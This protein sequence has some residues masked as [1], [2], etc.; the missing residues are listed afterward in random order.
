MDKT[1]EGNA[2]GNSNKKSVAV[3]A[4]TVIAIIF[5]CFHIYAA[6]FGT[7]GAFLQ[8]SIHLTFALV[9]VL[10][11]HPYKRW[12]RAGTF[13]NAIMI[14]GTVFVGIYA[15]VSYETM[16]DRAG[17]PNTLDVICGILTILLL[18]EASRRILGWALSIIASVCIAYVLFGYLLPPAVGHPGFTP[19][20]IIY[21]LYMTTEGIF[22][23]PLGVSA[24]FIIL[25]T[26]FGAV[27]IETGGSKFIS[28]LAFALFGR[29][30]GGP[31]KACVVSSAALGTMTGAAVASV[32]TVGIFTIPL[33]KKT[34][35]RAYMAG[36][37]EAVASTGA[38][39][40]PPV[41][42]AAAFIMAEMLQVPYIEIVIAAAL[43]A[44]LYYLSL[45]VV[46]DL[47]AAK[48]NLKGLPVKEL[49]RLGEVLKKGWFQLIPVAV[50]LVYLGYFQT[51][52]AK[53]ALAA[54][55]SAII[56]SWCF[57]E[58]RLTLPKI[59]KALE[60]GSKSGLEIAMATAAA[61]II[62]GAFTLSGLGM[63]L[64]TLL[65][66][67]SQGNLLLLLFITMAVAIILGM[68]MTTTDCYIILAILVAPALIKMGVYPIAAHLFVFYFGIIS[69]ITPPVALA[70]Q[71][72]AGIAEADFMKTGLQAMR[73]GLVAFILPYLFVYDPVL[74][75][76]GKPLEVIQAVLTAT[77]GVMA[78][79]AALQGYILKELTIWQRV[80]LFAG[81][82]CMIIPELMTDVIGVGL[83]L[84]ILALQI[85]AVR[86]EN[87]RCSQM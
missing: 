63:K 27:M 34:G 12:G 44:F 42:G 65:I 59:L 18:L 33:M 55:I 38:Q 46:I 37:I 9:L 53:A 80:I 73:L 30:R 2:K 16:G 25:F 20:R 28:D 60:N 68:G 76:N 72:S 4:I 67:L 56:V 23:I 17:N 31:A 70:A 62:V 69:A 26:I 43:P 87:V 32:A 5:S 6:S 7:F 40:T 14:L 75:L 58:T 22:G 66:A 54:I 84:M 13:I 49:P 15:G 81:S 3:F 47:E 82:V 77:V 35:Y 19:G 29:F 41:M 78:F 57:K 50:L 79:A 85:K 51:T 61:G 11:I 83:V 71:A 64:S 24:S 48:T 39:L 21:H 52:P 1:V 36:A 45:F 86:S 74:L 8:R 10:L